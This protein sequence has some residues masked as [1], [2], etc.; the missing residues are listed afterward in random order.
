MERGQLVGQDQRS[1]A[2]ASK[3]QARG[4]AGRHRGVRR[5]FDT[6]SVRMIAII[7]CS[8]LPLATLSGIISWRT[9]EAEASSSA[10]RASGLL[11]IVRGRI[12][13]DVHR[14]RLF[15]RDLAALP[16]LGS[17]QR[18][19]D[20]LD[21]ALA[22]QQPHLRALAL[23]SPDG[24]TLCAAGAPIAGLAQRPAFAPTVD[25]APAMAST[26]GF[27]L[28]NVRIVQGRAGRPIMT[29]LLTQTRPAGGEILLAQL[30]LGWSRDELFGDGRQS[31]LADGEQPL[32]AWLLAPVA[33]SPGGGS[34][35][36]AVPLCQDCDWRVPRELASLVRAAQAGDGQP[37]AGRFGAAAVATLIPPVEAL[38]VTQPSS[39]ERRALSVFILRVIAIV[40][41]LGLG[42]VA[43]AV[44]AHK[45]IVA[46]LQR[47]T[48]AV[49]QWRR[50][51]DYEV[52]RNGAR[53]M[54]AEL[55]ELSRAFTQATR[56]LALHERTL[57][58]AEAK[59]QL[60]IKEIHHRVKNNL[61]IIASLL[62]LQA[63]RIRQPE[64]RA[65]FASARDRVRALATLHR[66]LYSEGE[67]ET[68]NMRLF[69]RE[70]CSQLFQ[71]I[72]EREG[73]RIQLA[74]EAPEI[75][76]DTDQAVPLSLVVTEAVSNAVKYAFPGGRSGHI[77]VSLREVGLGQ[78]RLEIEDDGV[79]IPAGRAETETGI[80][81][82]L[83]IQLIRGFCRQLG[84]QLEVHEGSGTRYVLTFPLQPRVRN[85][86]EED[87]P[88]RDDHASG[89]G[90]A[91]PA[92]RPGPV[93][94]DVNDG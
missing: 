24:R 64:A 80:R 76:L 5:A 87:E 10:A 21:L 51:G 89:D 8:S 73:K 49:I 46:P 63:N 23:L 15:L 39:G 18:C 3:A 22:T 59:Q 78:G 4:L 32:R 71:A 56:S 72:G 90:V 31:T 47:L 83:G 2:R 94:A 27:A 58:E 50:A 35:V 74:I 11:A 68:L 41:G 17:G 25:A 13:D 91:R 55:R 60:L 29:A 19:A 92:A 62:N 88:D 93:G 48:A 65:E 6:V 36:A 69:L 42:L 57:R 9:Y 33:A 52:G 75:A 54:P 34:T 70:L 12:R 30:R 81:D 61:Q 84:G 37:V 26:S 86:E 79:G 82:G 38:A 43:V 16:A 7:L 1:G 44:G 53:L 40:L 67:L 45:L 85:D 77:R 66:Y 28:N 14:N 20:T